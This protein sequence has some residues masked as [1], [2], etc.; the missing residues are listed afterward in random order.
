MVYSE[1]PGNTV[2]KKSILP[3][4]L[5]KYPAFY[6]NLTSSRLPANRHYP[7]PHDSSPHYYALFV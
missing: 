4:L 2:L 3:Q 6:R 1:T 5:N 7:E